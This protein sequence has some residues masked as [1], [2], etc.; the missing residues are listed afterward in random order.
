[1]GI[2]ITIEKRLKITVHVTMKCLI[3]NKT[4]FSCSL[5]Y[6]ICVKKIDYKFL[7]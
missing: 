3:Y 4:S 5:T 1:M 2:D 6:L 7:P